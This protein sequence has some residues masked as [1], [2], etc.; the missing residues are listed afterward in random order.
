MTL[1]NDVASG[2]D[3]ILIWS[4]WPLRHEDDSTKGGWPEGHALLN[5]LHP[6]RV[7]HLAEA[8]DLPWDWHRTRMNWGTYSNNGT[9]C[10]FPID[11]LTPLPYDL[12][13]R[14]R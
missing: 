10:V 13:T 3:H 11:P 12:L 4:V 2:V 7:A 1:V 5:H 9:R 14:T 6:F 8:D